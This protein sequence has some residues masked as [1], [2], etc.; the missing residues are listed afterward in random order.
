MSDCSSPSLDAGGGVGNSLTNNLA[1]P[2]LDLEDLEATDAS[3]DFPW[4]SFADFSMSQINDDAAQSSSVNAPLAPLTAPTPGAGTDEEQ[5]ASALFHLAIPSQPTC[6]PPLLI[7]RQFEGL[8]RQKTANLILHTFKSY[9]LMMMHHNSLPP[10]IHPRLVSSEA[11]N[12]DMEALNNCISL[13]HILANGVP[14]SRKL[15]WRNVRMECERLH[16]QVRRLLTAAC[17]GVVVG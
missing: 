6:F 12:D 1:V 9:P 10:F 14:G 3:W 15:F 17:N 2:N 5:Q 7:Q 8:G 16:E 13:L 11:D 4:I